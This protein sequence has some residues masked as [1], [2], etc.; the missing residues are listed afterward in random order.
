MFTVRVQSWEAILT[1]Q[2][3]LAFVKNP[4]HPLWQSASCGNICNS[5]S[6]GIFIL[7]Q[8]YVLSPLHSTSGLYCWPLLVLFLRGLLHTLQAMKTGGRRLPEQ[9]YISSLWLISMQDWHLIPATLLIFLLPSSSSTHVCALSYHIYLACT[10][11]YLSTDLI[12]SYH[13]WPLVHCSYY[14]LQH[15]RHSSL[16][17]V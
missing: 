8:R 17:C 16:E 10:Q 1:S 15:S 3:T 5:H 12:W 13:T 9:D 4:R 14:T 6:L 11:C 2:A 7:L